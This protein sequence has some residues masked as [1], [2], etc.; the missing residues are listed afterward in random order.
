MKEDRQH[1]VE[2]S[3]VIQSQGNKGNLTLVDNRAESLTQAKTLDIIQY[4]D[5]NNRGHQRKI[6]NNEASALVQRKLNFNSGTEYL[7]TSKVEIDN[8]PFKRVQNKAKALY[9]TVDL[10]FIKEASISSAAAFEPFLLGGGKIKIKEL[11]QD[12]F[13]L[14]GYEYN[15]RLVEVTHETQ[16]AIDHY[17]EFLPIGNW[18]EKVISEFR[19]FAVQSAVSYQLGKK[20][21]T[22]SRKYRDMQQSFDPDVKLSSDLDKNGFTKGGFMFSIIQVYIKLYSG[23][24]IDL[25]AKTEKFIKDNE[26]ELNRAIAIYKSLR[27]DIPGEHD[28][29]TELEAYEEDG[30]TIEEGGVEITEILTKNKKVKKDIRKQP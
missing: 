15:D 24:E 23:D 6:T 10:D 5:I 7:D 11:T 27:D 12:E 8:E 9:K 18:T 29:I 3:R 2:A 4:Q 14:K 28:Y 22:H 16:H 21:K 30:E 20:N 19:A 13:D 26:S 1:K 25:D 17:E